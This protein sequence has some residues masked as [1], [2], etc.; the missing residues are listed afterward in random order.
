MRFLETAHRF[1]EHV[2]FLHDR[3]GGETEALTCDRDQIADEV[4]RLAATDPSHPTLAMSNSFHDHD[5][6]VNDRV[7]SY[8]GQWE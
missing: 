3:D 8:L 2:A 7:C 5:D 1:D 4:V 6:S